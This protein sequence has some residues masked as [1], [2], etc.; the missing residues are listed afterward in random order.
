MSEGNGELPQGPF[1]ALLALQDA[2]LAFDRLTHQIEHH[3]ISAKL[4]DLEGGFDRS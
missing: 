3:P 2:D 4:G 1:A